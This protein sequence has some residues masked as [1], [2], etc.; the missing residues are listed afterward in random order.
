MS[1]APLTEKRQDERY[2]HAP[3][4]DPG[5]RTRSVSNRNYNELFRILPSNPGSWF[6]IDPSEVTGMD[7]GDKQTALGQAAKQRGLRVQTTV[8]Q[9]SIYVRLTDEGTGAHENKAT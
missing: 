1:H 9:G 4:T 2:T 7:I 6:Q 5:T 8:Q 3:P